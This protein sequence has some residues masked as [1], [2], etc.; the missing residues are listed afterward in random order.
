M[1]YEDSKVRQIDNIILGCEVAGGIPIA[2]TFDAKPCV[3]VN[4]KIEKVYAAIIC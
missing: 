4:G 1:R 3:G 2:V